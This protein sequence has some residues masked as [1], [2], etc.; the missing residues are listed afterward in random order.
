M[1]KCSTNLRFAGF[2]SLPPTQAVTENPLRHSLGQGLVGEVPQRGE[3]A[4]V[5]ESQ[6]V[7]AA[8][9]KGDNYG[10]QTQRYAE[11]SDKAPE[12]VRTGHF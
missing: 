4:V 1:L 12:L 9:A 11:P 3:R 8:R 5:L 6:P 10:Q 2:P 7:V